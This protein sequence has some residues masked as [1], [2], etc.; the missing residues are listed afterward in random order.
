MR[1][2]PA[3]AKRESPSRPARGCVHGC[4]TALRLR[5]SQCSL[6]VTRSGKRRLQ[7]YT[8]APNAPGSPRGVDL[9]LNFTLLALVCIHVA[10]ALRA[11]FCRSRRGAD[12]NAA[13]I[14][15]P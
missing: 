13:A 3:C 10:V 14:L 1:R 4:E 2:S 12:P 8:G 6:R 7:H 15:E 5:E 9:T 11:P